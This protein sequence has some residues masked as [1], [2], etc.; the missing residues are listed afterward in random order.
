MPGSL[1]GE[2]GDNPLVPQPVRGFPAWC[3]SLFSGSRCSSRSCCRAWP[4][5]PSLSTSLLFLASGALVGD[6]FLGLIHV[7]PNSR[8][9]AATA[10]LALFTVLF[11]DGMHVAFP[12]LRAAWRDPAR[13]L[14]LGMPLAFAGMALWRTSPL[15]TFILL[16]VASAV[17]SGVVDNIPYV[18]TM[19][20]ITADL[21]HTVGQPYGTFLWWTLAPGCR[22]RRQRHRHRRLRQRRRARH[23]RRNR[24]PISFGTFTRYG[25]PSPP[26]P[27]PSPP[28][29]RGCATSPSPDHLHNLAPHRTGRP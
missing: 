13:V 21:P 2:Q 12:W 8:I 23:R 19:A 4:P 7:T 3:S 22:P 20:P 18:A 10:D 29:T 5:T 14:S 26:P 11:T 25:I 15:G 28:S 16:L 1:V 17:L 27:S 6:G 9:V 24:Q